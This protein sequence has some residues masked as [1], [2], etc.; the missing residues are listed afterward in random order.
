MYISDVCVGLL[1]E[2]GALQVEVELGDG[3]WT[4]AHLFIPR[5]LITGVP[6]AH[7]STTPPA[8]ASPLGVPRWPA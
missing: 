4:G 6:P 3:K 7:V 8:Y 5:H 2:M 1:S